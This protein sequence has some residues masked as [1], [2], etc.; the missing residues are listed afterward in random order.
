MIGKF[1]FYSPLQLFYIL[2]EYI[3]FPRSL[4]AVKKKKIFIAK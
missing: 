2:S 3:A 1:F 4:A